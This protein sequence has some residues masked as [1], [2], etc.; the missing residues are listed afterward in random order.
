MNSAYENVCLRQPAGER[1]FATAPAGTS[2]AGLPRLLTA[3]RGRGGDPAIPVRRAAHSP[4]NRRLFSRLTAR[5]SARPNEFGPTSYCPAASRQASTSSSRCAASASR[6]ATPGGSG[7]ARRTTSPSAACQYVPSRPART[8]SLVSGH[9]AHGSPISLS[10]CAFAP[11]TPRGEQSR[12]RLPSLSARERAL[13]TEA[14]S[15]R[16]AGEDVA[17]FRQSRRLAGGMSS[18]QARL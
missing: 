17:T 16:T 6:S 5:E 18:G 1:H 10:S 4:R 9:V 13:D 11:E 15:T 8:T 7:A 3:P 2:P 14:I 12:R